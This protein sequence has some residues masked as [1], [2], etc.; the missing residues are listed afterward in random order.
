[1]IMIRTKDRL[2]RKDKPSKDGRG[3]RKKRGRYEQMEPREAR[4]ERGLD[5]WFGLLSQ[6]TVDRPER[7]SEMRLFFR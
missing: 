5:S 4:G 7:F 2:E 6:M 3:K 1:M